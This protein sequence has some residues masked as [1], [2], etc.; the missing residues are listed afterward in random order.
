MKSKSTML[1]LAIACGVFLG[2]CAPAMAD[3][4]VSVGRVDVQLQGDGWQVINV[5]ERIRNIN[6]IGGFDIKQKEEAKVFVH[7]DA[8]RVMDAMVVVR[9][10]ASGNG[11]S[12]RMFYSN[13]QCR[14]NPSVYAE[15]DTPSP[16]ASSYKCL[17]VFAP[18][19][20]AALRIVEGEM[21]ALFTKNGWKTP[22]HMSSVVSQQHST[23]GAYA[24]VAAYLTPLASP[25][26]SAVEAVEAEK[27]SKPIPATVSPA[28]VQWARQLQEA[29]TDSVYSFGGDLNV[30]AM[31]FADQEKDA[32][33]PEASS[34]D[35]PAQA[36]AAPAPGQG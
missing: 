4:E 9:A 24:H 23:T 30:P 27:G 17:Q 34:A 36:P 19:S 1:K 8:N 10:N 2:A 26:K 5:G 22:S 13:A 28:S 21:A 3:Q 32:S 18:Q 20:V 11:S 14:G 6:S 15:G 31:V 12:S 16:Q 7:L 33:K 25:P 29:V 35:T